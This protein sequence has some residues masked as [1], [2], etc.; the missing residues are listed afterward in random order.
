MTKCFFAMFDI[1]GFSNLIKEKGTD[2]LYSLYSKSIVPMIQHAAMPIKITREVN[3]EKVLIPDPNSQQVLYSFF[4]DTIVFASIDD[5]WDSFFKIIYTSLELLKSG[6]NGSKAP[7]R[8]AIGYGDIVFNNLG[9]LIGTSIID[10]YKGEQGQ[11]WS[12]CIL[13]E[14]CEKFCLKRNY[15]AQWNQLFDTAL[16]NELNDFKR[17][18]IE[19]AKRSLVKYK[20]R[21]Q[22]KSAEKRIEYYTKEHFVLDWTQKVYVGAAKKSFNKSKIDHQEKIRKNTIAFENWARKYNQINTLNI[23]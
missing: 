4:S 19:K 21:K 1:I 12:G 8:G 6:F 9:I 15:F 20:V 14:E 3:G 18:D 22:R 11:M 23:K 7:Y 16:N 13:T 2:G 5:S 17:R 10:S